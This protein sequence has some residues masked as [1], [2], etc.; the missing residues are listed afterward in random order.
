MQNKQILSKLYKNYYPIHIQREKPKRIYQNPTIGR[1][2]IISNKSIRGE[3]LVK[4]KKTYH[5]QNK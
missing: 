2:K 4:Q 1:N 3:N 5:L